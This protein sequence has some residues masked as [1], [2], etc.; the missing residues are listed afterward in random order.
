V[1]RTCVGTYVEQDSKCDLATEL[2]SILDI[3]RTLD[4]YIMRCSRVIYKYH[5]LAQY[6]ELRPPPFELELYPPEP[7]LK[8]GSQVTAPKK[9]APNSASHV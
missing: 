5:F 1:N 6:K 8:G 4:T 2:R 9:V 3:N 7:A